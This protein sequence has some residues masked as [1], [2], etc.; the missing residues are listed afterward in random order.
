MLQATKDSLVKKISVVMCTYNGAA[1]IEEQLNSII[2]QTYPIFELIIQDD[3]STDDTY[4]IISEYAKKYPF[5]KIGRNSSGKGINNNFF[6]AIKK[7]E[8]DYIAISDQDDIWESDKLEIQ[9]NAIG[10]QMMCSCFSQPFSE[11]GS[12]IWFDNRIP[13]YHLLR[14]L[15]VSPL[16]GHTLLFSRH[17]LT[18]LKGDLSLVSPF[19]YYD[20]IL[21]MVAAANNS[22]IFI[23]K[24]LVHHRRFNS[25]ASFYKPQ[26]YRLTPKNIF[27]NII[28]TYK[29]YKKLKPE[30]AYRHGRMNDFLQTI[31]ISNDTLGAALKMTELQSQTSFSSYLKLTAF[32][33]SKRRYLF[34]IY[35]DIGKGKAML[36][37][38]AAYFP[39]SCSTYY[40]FLFWK[41]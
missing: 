20:V 13:N 12:P 41:K 2:N 26:D 14:L 39:I 11:D 7:A 3:N 1:F 21:E 5:V 29:T 37:A 24:V 19:R 23:D 16:P 31:G 25:S 27:R 4:K 8:G 35:N 9:I 6:S 17:L 33:I 40:R 28:S 30:I 34:H 36:M 22:I 32:C 15:F 18:Y 10:D 38:R